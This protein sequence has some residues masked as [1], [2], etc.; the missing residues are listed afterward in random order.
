LFLL[1]LKLFEISVGQSNRVIRPKEFLLF[2]AGVRF[3]R[4]DIKDINIYA[5]RG[6]LKDE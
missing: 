6:S 2:L 1:A 5:H 3:D 4:F